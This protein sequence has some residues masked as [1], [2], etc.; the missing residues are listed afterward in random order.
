MKKLLIFIFLLALLLSACSS[1]STGNEQ[2]SNNQ[3]NEQSDILACYKLP[4]I[5]DQAEYKKWIRQS[6]QLPDHFVVWKDISHLGQW[7]AFFL[8]EKYSPNMDTI[9]QYRYSMDIN[10]KEL[11]LSLDHEPNPEFK[12]ASF[13]PARSELTMLT[14]LPEME[15]MCTVPVERNEFGYLIVRNGLEYWYYWY[16]TL[17]SI[18]WYNDGIEYKL[19]GDALKAENYEAVVSTFIGKILSTNDS[20]FE[21]A[22]S[23]LKQSFTK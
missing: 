16:G 6:N 18:R 10:G 20:T 1:V 15:N 12:A 11:S 2:N 21:A 9:K 19:D 22:F 8:P 5:Q 23:E 3:T 7:R 14:I 17:S 4:L 13:A